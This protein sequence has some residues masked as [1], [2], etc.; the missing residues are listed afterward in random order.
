[1]RWFEIIIDTI[2]LVVIAWAILS[3]A[4]IVYPVDWPFFETYNFWRMFLT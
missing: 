4:T 3:W 1:M 2:S